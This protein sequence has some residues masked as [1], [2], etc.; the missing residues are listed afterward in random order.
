MSGDIFRVVFGPRTPEE[1]R[2]ELKQ[3]AQDLNECGVEAILSDNIQRDAWMKFSVV[4]S[5][6]ACGIFH[7]VKVGAMQ[8]PGPV[9]DDFAAFVGEIGAL[10]AAMGFPLGDDLA[11][12]NLAI[13]DALAPDASTSLKRDLD[14]GKPSE[15]D[16][17]IFQVVRLGRQYG[18][19]T[20]RY[21]AV[22]AKLGYVE[23][24][25]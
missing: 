11:E 17:L 25:Q 14:A 7:D 3:V 10:A 9:R 6:A 16:G 20:P 15:V 22:A 12:R 2:P 8:H 21:D 5:M 23:A 1:Y 4:S 24:A 18:V 13:Q 19:P